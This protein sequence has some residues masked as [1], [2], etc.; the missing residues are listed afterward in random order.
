MLNK[1]ELESLLPKL[2]N[3]N[4]YNISIVMSTYWS[5]LFDEA[6]AE[7]VQQYIVACGDTAACAQVLKD[8]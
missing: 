5:I 6:L 8:C 2:T 1:N 4:P 3:T 7:Y